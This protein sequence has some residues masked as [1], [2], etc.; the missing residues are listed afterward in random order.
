MA[1][2][3]SCPKCQK[4][5]LVPD[6]AS[7]DAV[8][9]CPL[10]SGEYSLGE[11]F[12]SAPP[13]LIVIH[14]GSAAATVARTSKGTVLAADATVAS[15]TEPLLFAGDQVE[16]ETPDYGRAAPFGSKD[17][18]KLAETV[19][20]EP[21]HEGSAEIAQ[22]VEALAEP[23]EDD[24]PWGGAWGGLKDEAA[25][26]EEEAVA[27]GEPEQEEGLVDFA[28][29]TGKAAPGSAPAAGA[30]AVEPP[31]KKKRKREANIF[32]RMAGMVVAAL[33]ALVCV[34]AIASWQG[35]KLDFLPA[36]MQFNFR[37]QSTRVDTPKPIVQPNVQ[38]NAPVNNQPPAANANP[39]ATPKGSDAS[40][41]GEN[42]GDSAVVAMPTPE[43]PK[44]PAALDS[45][46]GTELAMNVPPKEGSVPAPSA[47]TAAVETSAFGGDSEIKPPF[48]TGL[49]PPGTPGTAAMTNS[50]PF[51]STTETP[52]AADKGKTEPAAA[53][54]GTAAAPTPA[55]PA[56]KV[57]G[58]PFGTTTEMPA[59]AD[60][61]KTE[62]A[63]ASGGTAAA[64]PPAAE[65]A[66]KVEGD[67]F[68]TA[69]EMPAASD[70]GK[71]EPAVPNGETT[72]APTP[73][74]E[75]AA[76][77][78][79]DPLSL[80][81]I[82]PDKSAPDMKPDLPD[83]D[84]PKKPVEP[85]HEPEK[86]APAIP[87]LKLDNPV[88]GP[89][90]T[91]AVKPDA[92]PEPKAPEKPAGVAPQQAPSFPAAD[93]DA[94]LKALG[95]AAAVDAKSYADWCKL[96]EVATYV[97]DGGDAQKQALRTLT[98]KAASSPQ[99]AAEI[100]AAAKK[101]IDD[102]T[103]KGGIVLLGTVSGLAS[104]NGLS[105]TAIRMEGMAKP[106]MIFSA[107][108]LD[109]K[110]DEK[111]IVLGALVAEPAKNLP[112]YTGALPVV[113]WSDFAT[114]VR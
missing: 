106:V 85:Q 15:N 16:L 5:V 19:L 82:A 79:T 75:P 24:A 17:A 10:C 84:A 70:K 88:I 49:P 68:G 100:V 109:V 7:T 31:K 32:V 57:E 60:K 92:T 39:V 38:P 98:E 52:A 43:T 111:V 6:G 107:R 18:E 25:H 47:G 22:P 74:P 54:G 63:A 11:I 89:P 26:G 102:K 1:F 42:H 8:V 23:A 112:G 90:S 41:A 59:A 4:P 97:K 71:T 53:S 105:G 40:Q 101:L 27:L 3:S 91:P 73:A 86:N 33:L 110:Q 83:P 62:P 76:K 21:G 13:A 50:D 96:A 9:Q 77:T 99:A 66:A 67:P 20:F 114:A 95:G 104:K 61:G 94:S 46:Q 36:W 56:A 29:I 113:V 58:D 65:P 14:P 64:P 48:G 108:P 2:I 78:E 45:G 28:A 34:L 12:A 69:T 37:K 87:D 93:L 35:M 81:T 72:T 44:R 103:T 30:V 55:E 80:P 51:G